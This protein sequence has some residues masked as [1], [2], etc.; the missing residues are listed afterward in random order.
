MRACAQSLSS[1]VMEFLGGIGIAFIIWYGGYRVIIGHSHTGTFV[2]FLAA[3]MLL[4]DPVKK[5]TRLNN[6][7]QQGLA[8]VDR[9]FD[10]LEQESRDV[11]E[12]SQPGGDPSRAA[13]GGLSRCV[14][15]NTTTTWC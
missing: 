14:I 5:L 15:S 9:M 8:A 10:I 13:P 6:A 12:V 1:P 4:Y 7:V 11:A 3:V 2:S